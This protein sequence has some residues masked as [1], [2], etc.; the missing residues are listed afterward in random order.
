[1]LDIRICKSVSYKIF[2]RKRAWSTYEYPYESYLKIYVV[3]FSKFPGICI[4][5]TFPLNNAFE[6]NIQ[7]NY[8][9]VLLST[10]KVTIKLVHVFGFY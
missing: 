3:K 1:M 6:N 9:H 8:A 10:K 5:Y 2:I 4:M 7:H